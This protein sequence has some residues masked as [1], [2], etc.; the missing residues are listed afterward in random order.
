ML[1]FPLVLSTEESILVSLILITTWLNS[2]DIILVSQENQRC[3]CHTTMFSN[4][5]PKA[6]LSK[7]SIIELI[8]SS[9]F[10][11][12]GI[13]C[14]AGRFFLLFWCLGSAFALCFG[15]FLCP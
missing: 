9:A 15:V 5:A 7:F 10:L 14:V 4:S 12:A 3:F 2:E 8:L 13:G 1:A 6:C 11:G